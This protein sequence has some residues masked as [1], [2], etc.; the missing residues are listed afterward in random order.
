MKS[1]RLLAVSVVITLASRLR[2]SWSVQQLPAPKRYDYFVKRVADWERAW[3]LK[4]DSGWLTATDEAGVV[5][6]PLWAH[7]LFAEMCATGEWSKATVVPVDLRDL[8][9][10][11]LPQLDQDQ[12]LVSVMPVSEGTGVSVDPKRLQEDLLAELEKIE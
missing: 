5:H 10:R 11:L 4:G 1:R 9:D 6:L 12:Q 2:G 8:I 3:T 7:P